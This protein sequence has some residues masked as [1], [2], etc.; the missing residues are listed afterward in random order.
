MTLSYFTEHVLPELEFTDYIVKV[1]F[2]D[3]KDEPWTVLNE[4]LTAE[5]AH[6]IWEYDWMD[7][8][9][10]AEVIGWIRVEDVEVPEDWR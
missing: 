4:I 7:A 1:R 2:K 9:Y 8:T 5:G 10:E 6:W 3:H